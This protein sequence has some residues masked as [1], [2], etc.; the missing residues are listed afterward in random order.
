[1][2]AF[3]LKSRLTNF[4]CNF[5]IFALFGGTCLAGVSDLFIHCKKRTEVEK[6]APW[7]EEEPHPKEGKNYDQVNFRKFSRRDSYSTLFIVL[8]KF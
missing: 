5:K 2:L 7:V 8:N 6:I 4:K 1:M 3:L